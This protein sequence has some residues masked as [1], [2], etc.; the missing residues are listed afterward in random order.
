MSITGL[1]ETPSSRGALKAQSAGLTLHG[2]PISIIAFQTGQDRRERGAIK[3][4]NEPW[5]VYRQLQDF[6]RD[7]EKPGAGQ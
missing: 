7:P 3:Q 6:I 1:D 5:S 4:S 2:A